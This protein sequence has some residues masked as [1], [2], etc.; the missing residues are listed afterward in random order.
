M[1][2]VLVW[3]RGKSGQS[4][5]QFKRYWLDV[6]APLVRERLQGL[7]RY[8]VN[9]VTGAPRGEPLVQ[10]IAELHFDSQEAFTAALATPAGREVMIDLT[11]FCAESGAMFAEEHQIV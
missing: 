8:T 1:F 10:G 9:V 11:N 4:P 2:K 5:E 7:R 3:L 6:H